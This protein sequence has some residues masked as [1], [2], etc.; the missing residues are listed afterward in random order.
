MK[1]ITKT[2]LFTLPLLGAPALAANRTLCEPQIY[3]MALRYQQKS[4]EI[5][6]LQL[7]TYRFA[8]E[9]FRQ[10]VKNLASPDKGAVVLD[11]DETVLDNAALLVR[12]MQNCH[13]Y[14]AW[15]TWG[16]WEKHGKPTLIP[17]AK[18]FLDEVNRAGVAIFY[19]SDRTQ[20]NKQATL[21]TLKSLG[22]PQ[23]SEQSVLLDATSKEARR[24][25]ILKNHQII[26]LFGDSLPDFAAQFKN[27]K[28]TEEQ[29]KLVEASAAH[30][31]DDW[32]VLPNA[33]YGAWSKATLDGWQYKNK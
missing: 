2:L 32:I 16:D 12:D 28:P 14:T 20:Q 19:V 7:Q 21:A 17:G 11:L 13:D 10:K 23:V 15:D 29:R 24:Q 30:F 5:M 18:A 26:M 4:A 31:G 6:A 33:G 27:K 22:L 1:T 9:R 3:E 8:A 25:S